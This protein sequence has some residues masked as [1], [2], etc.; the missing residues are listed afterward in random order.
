MYGDVNVNERWLTLENFGYWLYLINSAVLAI[1]VVGALIPVPGV[2]LIAI[3][4][5]FLLSCVNLAFFI[6]LA[7][8]RFDDAGTYCADYYSLTGQAVF[9]RN[10]F[11]T[12]CFFIC[13]NCA[14][15]GGGKQAQ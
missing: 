3:G 6:T 4:I 13:C 12:L 11:I 2:L 5:H 8:W 10:I 1:A 14:L 7:T 9:L 15:S